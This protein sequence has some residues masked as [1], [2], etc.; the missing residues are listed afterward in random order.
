MKPMSAIRSASSSTTQRTAS[1]RTSPRSI[2]SSRRPG[3]ATSTSTPRRKRRELV[4]IADTAV[5]GVDPQPPGEG[6]QVGG[7][8]L[9]QLARRGQDQRLRSARIGTVGVGD[10]RDA[11]GECLARPGRC[12]TAHVTAGE[13]V[14]DRGGLDLEWFGDVAAREG[15]AD[16]RRHAE[17]GERRGHGGSVSFRLAFCR[18][19]CSGFWGV[20]CWFTFDK[21]NQR[22]SANPPARTRSDQPEHA[23]GRSHIAVPAPLSARIRRRRTAPD[24]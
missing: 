7:D 6:A 19:R 9:G 2:R 10:H 17:L 12:P 11:E 22:P 18:E 16:E 14:G 13:H 24:S 3:Q 23:T 20:F 21:K 15:V 1:R 5:D 8:L 4:A